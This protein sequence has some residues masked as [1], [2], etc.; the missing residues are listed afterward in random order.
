MNKCTAQLE[1]E[2]LAEFGFLVEKIV[3]GGKQTSFFF[4]QQSKTTKKT[5]KLSPSLSLVPDDKG[6]RKIIDYSAR[7][8]EKNNEG[9]AA[10]LGLK[11]GERVFASNE[12]L[13]ISRGC[14]DLHRMNKWIW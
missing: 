2:A 13:T 12:L 10:R 11:D 14:K 4:W 3:C 8:K 6:K 5:C 1:G 9:D 7:V